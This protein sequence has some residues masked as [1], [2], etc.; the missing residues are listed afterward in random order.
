MTNSAISTLT[1]QAIS[2]QGQVTGLVVILS[3]LLG[4]ALSWYGLGAVRWDV[5]LRQ[6]DGRAARVLRLL[7]AMVIASGLTGF[8]LQYVGGTTMLHG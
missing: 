4:T 6:P 2:V 1:A 8:V 5:F 7:L 3:L